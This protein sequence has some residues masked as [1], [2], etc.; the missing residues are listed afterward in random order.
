MRVSTALLNFL[1]MSEKV[2]RQVEETFTFLK[3]QAEEQAAALNR[4]SYDL[5]NKLQ[6]GLLQLG[7]WVF[8]LQ[9]MKLML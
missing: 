9:L 4:Y 3:I 2:H 5:L 7:I 6:L 8:H 1:Q